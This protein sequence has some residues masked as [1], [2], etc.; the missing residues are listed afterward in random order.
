LRSNLES[1]FD[2]I[3]DCIDRERLIPGLM[4]LYSGIDVLSSLERPPGEAVRSSFVRWA[5]RYVLRRN[6][7]GGCTAL[8]LYAARCGLVHTLT[9]NSA[10]S[11][12][13]NARKIY[14]AWGNAD[15]QRLMETA[16]AIQRP[17][18]VV[19]HVL[20]LFEVFHSGAEECLE[21]LMR[22]PARLRSVESKSSLWFTDISA[23]EITSFLDL[24]S[25]GPKYCPHA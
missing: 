16:V 5:E 9:A 6:P 13:G 10:F 14:Y 8:E 23:S 21:E 20:E 4:L 15:P 1:L 2:T 19:L 24:L 25:G 17:D 3:R 11:D 12:D 22:D 18:M 7:L